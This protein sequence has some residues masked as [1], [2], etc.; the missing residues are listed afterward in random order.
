MNLRD[1][2]LGALTTGVLFVVLG[3]VFL[4]DRLGVWQARPG[5]ILPTVVIGLGTAVLLSALLRSGQERERD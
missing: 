2:D 5:V 3:F 4:L 1:Y